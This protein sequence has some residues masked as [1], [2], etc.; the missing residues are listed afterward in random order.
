ME[1][2]EPIIIKPD[3]KTL[4]QEMEANIRAFNKYLKAAVK[5]MNWLELLCNCHP[6][7]RPRYA[8]RLYKS[9]MLSWDKLQEISPKKD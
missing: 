9:G 3:P 1:A 5:Q 6:V 2:E 4:R 7:E 8:W